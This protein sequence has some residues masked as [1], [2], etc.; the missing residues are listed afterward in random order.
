[1]ADGRFLDPFGAPEFLV[2]DIAYRVMVGSELIRMAFHQEENGES[3]I[4][5]K[6][7][8]PIAKLMGAQ[9][10]TRMFVARQQCRRI[11]GPLDL[12]PH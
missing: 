5:L 3:I 12:R 9:E 11:Q 10:G 6:L 4:R 2:D 1:M 8:F 7:V